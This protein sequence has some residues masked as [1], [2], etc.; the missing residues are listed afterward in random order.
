MKRFILVLI[1]VSLI[2]SLGLSSF[3]SAHP[4]GLEYVAET[5]GFIDNTFVLWAGFMPG[6]NFSA[7]NNG[8]L[9]TGIAGLIGT[10]VVFGV[11]YGMMFAL[12]RVKK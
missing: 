2:T 1:L 6:Y 8:F 7:F 3:A 5:E 10:M 4:D 11:L 9:A 12:L